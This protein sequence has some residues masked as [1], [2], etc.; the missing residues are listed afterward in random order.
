MTLR[1]M[2]YKVFIGSFMFRPVFLADTPV[3]IST[4][5]FNSLFPTRFDIIKWIIPIPFLPRKTAIS[6]IQPGTAR[7]MSAAGCCHRHDSHF[8][9]CSSYINISLSHNTFSF[10]KQSY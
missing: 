7:I 8:C 6:P 9:L 2:I 3:H 10:L 4:S 5:I 1:N